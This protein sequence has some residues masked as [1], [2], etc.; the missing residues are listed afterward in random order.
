MTTHAQY[1]AAAAPSS[2]VVGV[3]NSKITSTGLSPTPADATPN[4]F[5]D[6]GET[7]V[8]LEPGT[9]ICTV[10]IDP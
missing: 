6:T 4:T 10:V 8:D 9:Y 5:D 1:S 7:V 2:Q 3:A